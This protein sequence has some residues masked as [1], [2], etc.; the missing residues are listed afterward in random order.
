MHHCCVNYKL[1]IVLLPLKTGPF[2][3]VLL[4]GGS[5]AGL[6]AALAL[7]RARCS[8]LVLDAQRPRNRPT[9]TTCCC[10]MARPWPPWPP[11]PA[12]NVAA[13]LT[14][15]LVAAEA[16]TATQLPTGTFEVATSAPST[17]AARRWLATGL[18][19]ELPPIPGRAECW[20]KSVIHCPFCHGYEVADQ[21]A[22]LLLNGELVGHQATM[23]RNW[24]PELTAFTH[25][26]ATFGAAV[27]QQLAA[28]Q[29]R[30]EETPVAELLH[31]HGQLRALRLADGRYLPGPCSASSLS[32]A[33]NPF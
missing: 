33:P 5:Y 26:P 21:P 1:V 3:D 30:L 22:G 12:S 24:T 16:T 15:A 18:R 31:T 8:V 11:A 28:Q 19:D 14:V 13:Y 29:V 20:G 6:S 10:T 17:F 32:L 27:R 9:P 2:Y 7:G 23:L 25:G 4:L